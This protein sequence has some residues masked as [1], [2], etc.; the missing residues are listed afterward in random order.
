MVASIFSLLSLSIYN[1]FLTDWNYQS[2]LAVTTIIQTFIQ[3]INCLVFS[4]ENLKLGMPDKYFVVCSNAVSTVV[5]MLGWMPC[6]VLLAQLVP[7]GLESTMYAL[8][9]GSS[10]F[11]FQLSKFSGALLLKY[12]EVEPNGSKNEGHQFQNLYKAS[13]VGVFLP[14]ISLFLI[15]CLVPNKR[16]TEKIQLDEVGGPTSGSVWDRYFFSRRKGGK[17]NEIQHGYG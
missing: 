6:T 1:R 4:R 17:Q 16:Q 8:L 14:L 5:M 15:P 9:A 11:S 7:K 3:F 10:N 13:L 12:L 2:I